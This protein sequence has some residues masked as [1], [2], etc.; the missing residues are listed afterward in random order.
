[1]AY[2]LKAAALILKGARYGRSNLI[3]TIAIV[4]KRE[5]RLHWLRDSLAEA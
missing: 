2:Y 4:A 1:M 5:C 3:G